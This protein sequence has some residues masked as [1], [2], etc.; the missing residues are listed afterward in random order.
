M[1]ENDVFNKL[2]VMISEQLGIDEE[3]IELT[4][5]LLD[6]L[7]ADS[8][9]IV[10]ASDP[11]IIDRVVLYDSHV[12]YDKEGSYYADVYC[13]NSSGIS[14][15]KKIKINVSNDFLINNSFNSILIIVLIVI[16][17]LLSLFILYYFVIRKFIRKKDN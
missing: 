15:T 12:D 6:D 4:S 17:T 5:T 9:D 10:D 16:I 1:N 14:N 8:L 2:K 7:S 3:K 13:I 11:N